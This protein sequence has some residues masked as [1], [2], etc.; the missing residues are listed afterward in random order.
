V[1]IASS[2]LLAV[3]TAAA[4]RNKEFMNTVV[5]KPGFRD[6]L[7][8]FRWALKEFQE[9]ENLDCTSPRG[10][11][12][13]DSSGQAS[14]TLLERLR[15]SSAADGELSHLTLLMERRKAG[16]SNTACSK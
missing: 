14:C 4:F 15:V 6:I 9:M 3:Q 10:A 8:L 12:G 13:K 11:V 2:L 1:A 7:S 16:D 5:R